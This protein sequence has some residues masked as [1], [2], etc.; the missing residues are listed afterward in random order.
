MMRYIILYPLFFLSGVAGLGYEILWSRLLAV[1]L[2]HEII[3]ML[4]VVS[5]FFSG[6]A[7]GSWFFDRPVSRS[8]S[9]ALWYAAFELIIGIWAL[10][11][12]FIIPAATP[13]VSS[14]IGIEPSGF[15]HMTVAFLYPFA[16]LLPA[17]A[18]MGGTLPAID[19]F[20]SLFNRNTAIAGLYSANT[21]GAMAGTL[22]VTFII[23]PA[24]GMG[25]AS[26]LLS[27]LNFSGTA[28]IL[29]LARKKPERG[30]VPEQNHTPVPSAGRLMPILFCTGL[31]G[32]GFEVVMVRILSQILENTIFSFAAL[33]TVFL[34][35]TAAGAALYHWR[36]HSTSRDSALSSLL[37]GTALL[38]LGSVFILRYA[39]PLFA[40]AREFFGGGFPGSIAAEMFL[41]AII[42]L[43]PASAMGA[44][45]SHL[46][47]N[48]RSSDGGVGRALC[49]N[50]LG[51]AAAP[52][53]FGIL[54][55]PALGLKTTLLLTAA[56][57][58]LLVPRFYLRLPSMATI[59]TVIVF[60]L[61]LDPFSFR[62]ISVPEEEKI[63]FYREG[64]MA[65]V[66]VLEDE[67][68]EY[69]LKVN[70]RYQMGGTTSLY[71]DFRQAVL[72][73]MLHKKPGSALFLGLGTGTTFAAAADFPGLKADGV[74]IIP[75][76]IEAIPYFTEANTRL[77][78]A[79]NLRI[80]N[81]DARRYVTATDK[82]Y[83]VIIADLFHPAR[84]GAG[85]L[86]TLEHFMAIREILTEDGLFCQ[87][88]PLYQ[89]DLKMLK[90]I[91]RTF[92]EAFPEGQAYLAHYSL[93]SPIIG[94][95]G[96]RKSLRYPEKWFRTKLRDPSVRDRVLSLGYDS[97]YSL[98]GTFL[99]DNR[100]LAEFAAG[101]PL[102]TD[103]F[104]VVLLRAP[105]FVYEKQATP[106]D[107]LITLLDGF[108]PA[109]PETVLADYITEEDYL[110]RDR[111]AAYWRARNSY[112]KTGVG[113]EPTADVRTLYS[114]AREPLLAA[115]RTSPDFSAA[116]FPLLSIAYEIY[117]YDRD[118]SYQLLSDLVRANPMRREAF[119]LRWKLFEENI[120]GD[121]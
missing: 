50:T 71:S 14:L 54:L 28:A 17:T 2:G 37:T 83:D 30:Y 104:P 101:S 55:I 106:A 23:L 62:F 84:D 59:G 85:G 96:S 67:R 113:I 97:V 94:L 11:L 95:V 29:L 63:I 7:V 3:S 115:V 49:L 89:L 27:L 92:L 40:W 20:A 86:Y 25:T 1:G 117:P 34:F 8:S 46:A 26:L 108:F 33:L 52:F 102:N 48:L 68:K 42:F 99:A 78:S 79:E 19:R 103:N 60:F 6:I 9:P 119:L 91:I 72:P 69:H 18:A 35:G 47:R 88:L 109:D 100:Q 36:G 77:E 13:A 41:A 51:G 75:E 107:R 39:D 70:N 32:I 87:W 31:L 15:R 43:L 53:L 56:G 110:A 24:A 12:L 98:L 64:I 21:F 120:S 57:Y 80:I 45:F 111:L 118:A 112:M 105:R 81:A 38:C 44:T 74:E 22:G 121:G 5:A 4:A 82:K 90:V 58:F 65:S 73:L 116:Y 10:A 93:E 16:L 61:F 76:I 66:S 114:K